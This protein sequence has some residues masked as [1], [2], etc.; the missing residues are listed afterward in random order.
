MPTPC[1]LLDTGPG[2]GAFNMA[3][4][5]RLLMLVEAGADHCTLRFF[6]W[7]E[8]TVS[9]GRTQPHINGERNLVK[10]PTGG[11]SVSHAPEELSFSFCW[12]AE[13]GK[14]HLLSHSGGTRGIYKSLHQV[15]REAL[16]K[17]GYDCDLEIGKGKTLDGRTSECFRDCVES[18]ILWGGKK[19]LGGALRR[20]RKAFLYQGTLKR[21]LFRP[22]LSRE[23]AID[24]MTALIASH[25]K[26]DLIAL[27]TSRFSSEALSPCA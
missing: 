11:G 25:L 20:T 7:K 5:E 8:P 15:F 26:L 9:I 12:P 3:L 21:E 17:L 4:D 13:R 16:E 14:P 10:R 22:G 23:A 18:D 2:E 19:I 6:G 24:A 1:Y 27:K